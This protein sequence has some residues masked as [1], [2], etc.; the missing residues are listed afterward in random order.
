MGA[1]DGIFG[2]RTKA[3]VIVFQHREGLFGE[4]GKW[5]I[6]EYERALPD[7]TPFSMDEREVATPHGLINK[8]DGQ[9]ADLSLGKR[10]AGTAGAVSVAAGAIS[11]TDT[12]TLTNWTTVITDARGVAEPVVS[13]IQWA[14]HSIWIAGALAC[15]AAYL[16][17][18][19]AQARHVDAIQQG[20]ATP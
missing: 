12:A 9:A 17:F 10:V 2:E 3:A 5:R 19:R 1:I 13:A 8:G 7:A 18:H 11:S 16:L 6:A 20:K 4:P 15:V 14:A